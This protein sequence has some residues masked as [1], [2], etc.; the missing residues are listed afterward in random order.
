MDETKV[1]LAK[2]HALHLA[3]NKVRLNAS[4]ECGPLTS[5]FNGSLNVPNQNGG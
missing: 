3:S 5:A 1:N 4:R 2:L